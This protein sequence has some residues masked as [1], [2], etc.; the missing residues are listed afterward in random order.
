MVRR[1]ALVKQHL[2]LEVRQFHPIPVRDSDES[3]ARADE[4][5]GYHTSQ[6]PAPYKQHPPPTQALLPPA[7]DLREKGLTMVT[8]DSH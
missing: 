1:V 2:A 5:L 7:I 8:V 4:L 3:D 6:S